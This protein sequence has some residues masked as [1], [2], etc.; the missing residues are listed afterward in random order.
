MSS[1]SSSG[2]LSIVVV[3]LLPT[4][5]HF[6]TCHTGSSVFSNTYL[7]PVVPAG[8]LSLASA[9]DG[10]PFWKPCE[11]APEDNPFFQKREN[12]H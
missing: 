8:V 6:N 4:S 7:E 3:R 10:E 12:S 9:V 2:S 1:K 5:P 11:Q